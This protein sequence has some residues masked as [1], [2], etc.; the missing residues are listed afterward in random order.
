MKLL[1]RTAR[2]FSLRGKALMVAGMGLASLASGVPPAAGQETQVALR[3]AVKFVCGV[4]GGQE[5]VKLPLPTGRYHTVINVHN[6]ALKGDA[7]FFKKVV[8]ASASPYRGAQHPGESTGFCRTGLEANHAFEIDCPEIRNRTKLPIGGG[9]YIDGFVVIMSPSELD[10]VAVYTVRATGQG[11][12]QIS[13]LQ[14][15]P[16]TGREQRELFPLLLPCR[17]EEVLPD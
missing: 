10:V 1:Q 9:A 3:Y 11:G 12:G 8:V 6:P 14:V 4:P 17:P 15:L 16:I 7:V 5:D 13:S 2:A